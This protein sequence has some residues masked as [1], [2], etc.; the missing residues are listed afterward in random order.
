MPTNVTLGGHPFVCV[1]SAQADFSDVAAIYV[2]LCVAQDGTWTVLD[3][4]QSGQVG[5]NIDDH[6]RKGC[7]KRHCPNRKVWV[8]VH[9]MPR[10]QY[11]K[12]QREQFESAFRTRLNPTCGKR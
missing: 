4:G 11:T 12:Q 5:S 7:W 2:I 3:V 1:P 8:C 10:S 6:D 9:R